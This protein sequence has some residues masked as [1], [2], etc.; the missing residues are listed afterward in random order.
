MGG[1]GMNK[2]YGSMRD[3]TRERMNEQEWSAWAVDVPKD[4]LLELKE[5]TRDRGVCIKKLDFLPYI[6]S[7]NPEVD[8]GEIWWRRRY[9]VHKGIGAD[10]KTRLC[11]ETTYKQI[12]PIDAHQLN[13]HKS[14]KTE[15]EKKIASDLYVKLRDLYNVID[16]DEEQKGI[17]VFDISYHLFG[18]KLKTELDLATDYKYDGFADLK[19]GFTLE[20][21]FV[22]RTLGDK[23]FFEADRIDFIPRLDYDAVVLQEAIDLDSCLR[24]LSYEQLE[25]EFLGLANDT[26]IASPEQER[27]ARRAARRAS[28]SIPEERTEKQPY[29]RRD[30]KSPKESKTSSFRRTA[31]LKGAAGN[32]PPTAKDELTKEVGNTNIIDCPHGHTLGV[33]TD[34]FNECDD[35]KQYDVCGEEYDNRNRKSAIKNLSTD[36]INAGTIK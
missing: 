12:C 24:P 9:G 3:R 6:T 34:A 10:N 2:D 20:I 5:N 32:P 15:E 19:G 28:Q 35:C 27:A 11:L 30:K 14:A 21:R 25:R 13:M 22:K 26:S 31:P 18:K 33:D 16:L 23:E 8:P 4:R 36:K 7:N 29:D 17:Q 1:S